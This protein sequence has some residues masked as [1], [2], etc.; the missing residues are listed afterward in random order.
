[1]KMAHRH[2][3]IE[4]TLRSRRA[5]SAIELVLSRV[6]ARYPRDLKRLRRVLKRFEPLPREEATLREGRIAGRVRPADED[7]NPDYYD[8]LGKPCVVSVNSRLSTSLVAV[9]AHELGHACTSQADFDR[10][11]GHRDEWTFEMCADNYAHKWG[12]GEEIERHRH[13]RVFSHH[14][15]AP[16]SEFTESGLDGVWYR[17]RVTPN[18]TVV[19]VQSETEDGKVIETAEQARAR[20][21]NGIA[22][23][24]PKDNERTQ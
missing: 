13:E 11:A 16:N 22:P 18:F 4:C 17:F 3:G 1:M 23:R 10:R 2:E 20:R 14:G 8:A 24:L 5:C 12:F 6:R 9:I 15:P 19:F 7:A 21:T